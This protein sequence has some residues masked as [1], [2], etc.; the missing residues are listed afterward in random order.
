VAAVNHRAGTEHVAHRFVQRLGTV[1][2]HQDGAIRVKAALA[3]SANNALQAA[4][5]SVTP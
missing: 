5:F 1:D 3:R 2:H 4:A